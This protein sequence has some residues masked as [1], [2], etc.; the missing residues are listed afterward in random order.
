M[1]EP[2]TPGT[3]DV[4]PTPHN[5]VVTFNPDNGGPAFTQDVA[6]EGKATAP[7]APEK[8]GC[9]FTG[10]Y[11]NENDKFDFN[12]TIT[13]DTTLTAHWTIMTVDVSFDPNGGNELAGA[14]KTKVVKI[15]EAYGDLPVP[16]RT[17]YDFLGWYTA[18]E[19]GNQVTANTVV[20]ATTDHTL[21]ARWREKTYKDV[22]KLYVNGQPAYRQHTDF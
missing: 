17:G 3:E 15:G 22:A 14:D 13:A 4:C 5:W 20:T 1:A 2:V 7:D 6:Y 9:E 18:A 8:E 10:W 21:Y 12:T 16:T 19:E 11:L